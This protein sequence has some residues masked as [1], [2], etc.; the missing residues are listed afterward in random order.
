M[1]SSS[2]KRKTPVS[3]EFGKKKAKKGG[4]GGRKQQ[5]GAE[6]ER[7]VSSTQGGSIGGSGGKDTALEML[8]GKLSGFTEQL[9]T[10]G[11]KF[12]VMEDRLDTME[13]G[14]RTSGANSD[15]ESNVSSSSVQFLGTRKGI[16]WKRRAVGAS[17]QLEMF[18]RGGFGG[19]K[20]Q[21]GPL[22][23]Q[24][25]LDKRLKASK[26]VIKELKNT[27]AKEKESHDR[28]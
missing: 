10:I 13:G 6:R 15:E 2:A 12:S 17:P 22:K 16:Q 23:G 18:G 14:K 20:G 4:G 11:A 7:S 19:G 28:R 5:K 26:I 3:P 27:L 1:P 9:N 8:M 24:G 25:E 21:K